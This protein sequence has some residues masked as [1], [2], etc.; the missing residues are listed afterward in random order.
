M[1]FLRLLLFPFSILYGFGVLLRNLAYD[2]G[3]FK[4]RKFHLPVISIGNLSVGGSGKSPMTEYLIRILKWDF[5]LAVVSRGYGRSTT[6]FRFVEIDDSFE[7]TGDEPL[8]IKR[9]FEGITVAVN[10]NRVEAIEYIAWENEL[11]ILDDAYQHR[12]VMPGKNIL[13]FE[14]SF[15]QSFQLLLPAGNLREPMSEKKRADVVI[16]TKCPQDINDTQKQVIAKKLHLKPNQSLFFSFLKYGTLKSLYEDRLSRPVCSLNTITR[17][18][19]LTGIA[20]PTPLLKELQKYKAVV[21]HHE[22]P[23]HHNFTAKNIAKLVR[24]FNKLD[25]G[26]NLIITTEKDAQR[27]RSAEF[28]KQLLGIPVFYLPIEADFNEPERTSLNKLIID[29]ATKSAFDRR[30]H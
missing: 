21:T 14:Y 25:A 8:Q 15:F 1:K 4:S 29:Y 7:A 30:L 12:A 16:V 2:C 5:T 23:D 13:L 24:A 17:I 9:K 28:K 27:L 22:Y 6:G 11:I 10:E 18:I 3:I 19:L 20:N 26:E